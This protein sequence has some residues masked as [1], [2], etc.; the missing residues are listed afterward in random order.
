MIIVIT[1][2]VDGNCYNNIDKFFRNLLSRE[3]SDLAVSE[4]LM[5]SEYDAWHQQHTLKQSGYI[6]NLLQ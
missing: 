4:T 5:S 1:I 2:F 3:M 6:L